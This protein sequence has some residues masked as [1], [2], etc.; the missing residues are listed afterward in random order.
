M[1]RYDGGAYG[2][3][4][5]EGDIHTTNQL[6]AGLDSRPQAKTFI[7]AFL[8]GAGDAKI[9]SVINGDAVSGK[10][11]KN[12]FLKNLPAL[13][14]LVE[15]VKSVAK[16]GYLVGLDGRRIH[17]RSPHAALNTLL[18][19]AGAIVCKKWLVLL[20]EQLQAAGL[21]HGWGGDY[22]FCAWSHDEVQIACR[23]P[24][25]A[26]QVAAMA[27]DCVRLAGEHYKFRCPTAG[28]SKIG[29]NWSDTH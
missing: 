26:Q 15:D 12:K 27:T 8:Y 18:Q 17:V 14:R 23:T 25:I 22:C 21:K 28:E 1:A 13:G 6:A 19:G 2:K 29:T 9:G 20:E 11:L 3:A 16:R 5:L 4:L 24:E 10:R 7:Y